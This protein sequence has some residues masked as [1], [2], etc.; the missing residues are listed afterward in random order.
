MKQNKKII[1]SFS[2]ILNIILVVLLIFSIYNLN[3][4][5]PLEYIKGFYQST[6]YLPDVYE[7]NFTEKEFFIKFNDSIIEKGKYHKYKNNIYICYGEKSIQVVSL[8]NKNF[9]IYDNNN[10]RVIELK[11]I[12]NIPSS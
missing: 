3:K 1:L 6:E 9:Y 7:F 2:L 8:L 5:K 4:E 12:S 10:N 11:K